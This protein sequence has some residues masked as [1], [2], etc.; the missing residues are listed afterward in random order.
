MPQGALAKATGLSLN[1]LMRIERGLLVP[2][3]TQTRALEKI[4]GTLPLSITTPISGEG[5]VTSTA[6]EGRVISRVREHDIGL[7]AVWDLFCGVGGFSAGFEATGEF[8]VVAGLDLLG[9]RLSTFTSNHGAA[10]AYG[11]DIRNISVEKL[12][13]ENERPFAIIGG[14]PCQGFSSIR[15]FRNVEWGDLRNNLG[16]EFCRFVAAAR[17]KW[18]V[19]EN[20]VGLL[21]HD[22][23]KALHSLQEAFE[24]L[25]YRISTRVMNAAFHGL[26]QRRERLIIV[27]SLEGK[28]FDWPEPSHSHDRR[29]MAGSSRLLLAPKLG[30]L[31]R[32]QPAVTLMEAIGNLP[33]V[34]SGQSSSVYLDGPETRYQE[35]IRAGAQTLTMHESTA[36]SED[37]LNIIRHAGDNI[38]ALP[39]GLVTSGFSSCYSRL[40]PNEQV[41][42]AF[43]HFR[44]EL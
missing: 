5:Y 43:T 25:G 27:G 23:G 37:M 11:G 10:N 9:D 39:P 20:V 42:A 22:G 1:H 17:P 14:P 15:P 24:A 34:S 3:P 29:S 21:T 44:I 13:N 32:A 2:N 19:F 28:K 7:R 26:P 16:E 36:H 4:L 30:L 41:T 38:N 33:A 40:A 35:L 6:A 12:L 18:L 31:E 8:E